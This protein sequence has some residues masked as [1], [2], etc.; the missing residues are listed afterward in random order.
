MSL[1]YLGWNSDV[2]PNEIEKIKL[3]HPKDIDLNEVFTKQKEIKQSGECLFYEQSECNEVINAHSIQKSGALTLIAKNGMVYVPLLL[4]DF[5]I[6]MTITFFEQ[7]M[8]T[9]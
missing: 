1:A 4:E 2:K 5:A 6:I 8:T 3:P 9:N 7:L